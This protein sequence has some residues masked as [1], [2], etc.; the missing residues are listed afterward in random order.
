M[1]PAQTGNDGKLKPHK[2]QHHVMIHS[3]HWVPSIA[4]M[5]SHSGSLLPFHSL[6]Y[7]LHQLTSITPDYTQGFPSHQSMDKNQNPLWNIP[8]WP[9]G[10]SSLLR[11]RG[12]HMT[13]M[14][15]C[16][17]HA[18]SSA[19]PLAGGPGTWGFQPSLFSNLFLSYCMIIPL[20]FLHSACM[21]TCSQS[22]LRGQLY[23]PLCPVHI[24]VSFTPMRTA[25]LVTD[26]SQPLSR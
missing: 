2:H 1:S 25:T 20:W 9:Q 8:H 11:S 5:Q 12:H 6:H 10:H 4:F 18:T 15:P 3:Q 7:R 24:P 21:H 17:T 23:V 22:Q 14:Q 16:P 19:D 26:A 13:I